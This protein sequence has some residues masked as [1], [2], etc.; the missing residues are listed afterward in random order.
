MFY[1][2]FEDKD[3]QIEEGL[4]FLAE[5]FENEKSKDSDEYI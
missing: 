5:I 3:A 1:A 4:K 2:K